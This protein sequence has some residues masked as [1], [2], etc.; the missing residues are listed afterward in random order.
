MRHLKLVRE[1]KRELIKHLKEFS[2]PESSKKH[3]LI[4]IKDILEHAPLTQEFIMV[5]DSGELDPEV[6]KKSNLF[7]Q[8]FLL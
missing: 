2:K 4:V 3:K 1:E 5:G 8:I 7:S 6:R